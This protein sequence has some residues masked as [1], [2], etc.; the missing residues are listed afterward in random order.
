MKTTLDY[1][2]DIASKL[3]VREYALLSFII[4]LDKTRCVAK[5]TGLRTNEKLTKKVLVHEGAF[6][7]EAWDLL[8]MKRLVSFGA[9]HE[10]SIYPTPDAQYVVDYVKSLVLEH[11]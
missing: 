9:I 3:T 1:I 7:Q 8:V 5:E 6:D 10:D 4:Y 11:Q 2:R